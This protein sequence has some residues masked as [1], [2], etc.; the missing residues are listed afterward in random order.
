VAQ[1]EI[2]NYQHCANYNILAFIHMDKALKL[3]YA[4]WDKIKGGDFFDTHS[5]ETFKYLLKSLWNSKYQAS[6]KKD[7]IKNLQHLQKQLHNLENPPPYLYEL[8]SLNDDL[9][10]R[11]IQE[12][13]VFEFVKSNASEPSS[14]HLLNLVETF[15]EKNIPIEKFVNTIIKHMLPTMNKNM[16]EAIAYIVCANHSEFRKK[17]LEKFM[18]FPD[19]SILKNFVNMSGRAAM[20]ELSQIAKPGI[21]AKLIK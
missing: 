7:I 13:A 10:N 2:A 11:T 14:Y 16:I 20:L 19:L 15:A 9:I 12:L 1:L 4:A 17:F 18:N 8:I 6:I 5:N 21:L 3:F